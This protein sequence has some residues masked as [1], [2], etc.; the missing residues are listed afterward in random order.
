MIIIVLMGL[1]AEGI[2]N[3]FIDNSLRLLNKLNCKKND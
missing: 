3:E 2:T 1:Y